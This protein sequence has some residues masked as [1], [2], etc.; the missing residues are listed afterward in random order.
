MGGRVGGWRSKVY[1]KQAM[2]DAREEDWVHSEQNSERGSKYPPP[3][4]SEQR[5]ERGSKGVKEVDVE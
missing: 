3:L 1:S 4:H 5:R 2:L